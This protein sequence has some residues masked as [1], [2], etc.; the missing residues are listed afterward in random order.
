MHITLHAS[1]CIPLLL[2][3][4]GVP[5]H[6]SWRTGGIDPLEALVEEPDLHAGEEAATMAASEAARVADVIDASARQL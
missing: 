5:S 1:T 6:V 3:S 4:T 2:Q